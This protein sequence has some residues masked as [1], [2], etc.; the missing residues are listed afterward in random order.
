VDNMF[1]R[2]L[3][4]LPK[5]C[6]GVVLKLVFLGNLLEFMRATRRMKQIIPSGIRKKSEMSWICSMENPN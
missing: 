2:I 6:I 1:L 3:V 5:F 4:L